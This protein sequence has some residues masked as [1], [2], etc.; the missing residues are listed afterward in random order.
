MPADANIGS[1]AELRCQ[2]FGYPF[3]TDVAWT[4]HTGRVI[5]TY[6]DS[7][8]EEST[9]EGA[10]SVLNVLR[11]TDVRRGDFREY[12]CTARN[13]YGVDSGIITLRQLGRENSM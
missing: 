6:R 9:V 13:Q 4:D 12:N 11:I 2:V 3:P 8:F 10:D 7:R 5:D 1:V